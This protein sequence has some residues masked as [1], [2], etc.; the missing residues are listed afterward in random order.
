MDTLLHFCTSKRVRDIY[1]ILYNQ[2]TRRFGML[3]PEQLRVLKERLEEERAKLLE[4]FRKIEDTQS[5][6]GEQIR[7]PG[8]QED[9]SQMTYTQE[10]LDNLSA[11]EMF[12][13]REIDYA[14]Q[15]L[16]A[17]TYG[18]CEYCGEYIEYERL[19][20][21]PWTRYHAACAEKAEEEGIV[22][23]YTPI[24]FEGTLPE[25]ME[26]QREDITEA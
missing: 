22:P 7:E 16:R 13:I 23:T 20:A 19:L 4:R 2:K 6:I 12:I 21:I 17:G 5:R 14:L 8:D 18:V 24:I 9:L 3:T 15:K 25:E 26:I 1:Y 10:V 11:R